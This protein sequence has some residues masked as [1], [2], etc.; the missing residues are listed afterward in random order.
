MSLSFRFICGL[1]S[2]PVSSFHILSMS[3]HFTSFPCISIHFL[4][5]PAMVFI[6]LHFHSFPFN[7]C[8][9]F[10]FLSCPRIFI[11]FHLGREEWRRRVEKGMREWYEGL[12][13]KSSVQLPAT[14]W[15]IIW[16]KLWKHP[17]LQCFQTWLCST[18]IF[19]LGGGRGG[20]PKIVT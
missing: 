13:M 11:H 6:S 17:C 5:I 2:F 3:V 4:S 18:Y 12:I 8:H 9:G 16:E 19:Y 20:D 15:D 1:L 7:S 14:S 10:H